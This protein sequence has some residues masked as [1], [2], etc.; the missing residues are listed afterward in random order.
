MIFARQDLF[1][2]PDQL[3]I[4]AEAAAQQQP[5]EL[6]PNWTGQTLETSPSDLAGSVPAPMLKKKS[7]LPHQVVS[8]TANLSVR[9]FDQLLN[10]AF[11]MSPTP[12]QPLAIEVHPGS[13]TVEDDPRVITN[14]RHERFPRSTAKNSEHSEHWCNR[15]PKPGLRRLFL[16]RRLVD[17]QLRLRFELTA[18]LFI[19]CGDRL[20]DKGLNFDGPRR[21]A[22]DIQQITEE[23][24]RPTFA[25]AEM[26]HQQPGEGRQSRTTLAG[27]HSRRQT[28]A[29]CDAA[30]RA[31]AAEQLVFDDDWFDRRQVPDL[32]TPRSG[33]V[34]LQLATAATAGI[35]VARRDGRT[36]LTG[37]QFAEVPLVSILPA[38][39]AF[40]PRRT[41]PFRPGMRMLRAG[42]QRR[43]ARGQLF[44]LVCQRF[45]LPGQLLDSFKQ[46]QK[47]R[48]HGGSHFGF[49]FR[50]YGLAQK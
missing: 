30:A 19:R 21:A 50:R 34:R 33:T 24:R 31:V 3:C 5:V 32:V 36:L 44:D 27:W 45:H 38:L 46:R 28:R 11:Q 40:F 1:A 12:L 8:Q 6:G 42:R 25:L 17:K 41:L 9:R 35:G 2:E 10:V 7:L 16:R 4:A 13:I 39:P 23:H 14:Q 49:E 37:D 26:P 29:R 47:R 15:D 20:A 18:K 22:G 48:L 43:I